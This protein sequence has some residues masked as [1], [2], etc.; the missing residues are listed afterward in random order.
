MREKDI[1]IEGVNEDFVWYEAERLRIDMTA[2]LNRFE[3]L[4]KVA[5]ARHKEHVKM[6]ADLMD[7]NQALK[8]Q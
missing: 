4:V 6:L 3:K 7:E 1:V 2:W 5:E 8:K